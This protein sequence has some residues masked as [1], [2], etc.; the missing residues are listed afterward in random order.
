MNA[1]DA[2]AVYPRKGGAARRSPF[3]R[4]WRRLRTSTRFMPNAPSSCRM[5]APGTGLKKPGQPV[6]L[7]NLVSLRN[8][9]AFCVAKYSSNCFHYGNASC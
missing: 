2:G 1:V 9:G 8:R 6:P 3:G 5:I 7:S 4:S